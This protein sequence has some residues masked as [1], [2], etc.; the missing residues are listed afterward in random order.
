MT[1][2]DSPT[3]ESSLLNSYKLTTG[4]SFSPGSA[5]PDPNSLQPLSDIKGRSPPY[6]EQGKRLPQVLKRAKTHMASPSSVSGLIFFSLPTTPKVENTP[7]S[8][9]QSIIHGP[10]IIDAGFNR[11][12]AVSGC[13]LTIYDFAWAAD[14]PGSVR[15]SHPCSH[16]LFKHY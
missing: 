16:V 4:P 12:R 15:R 7:P 2:R 6:G 1:H 5:V 3:L 14:K 13:L 11:S 8:N 9:T 10:Y